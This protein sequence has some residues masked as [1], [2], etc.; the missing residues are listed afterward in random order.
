MKSSFQ[1]RSLDV[2]QADSL[3]T[4]RRIV[5]AV[6]SGNGSVAAISKYTGVSERHVRY[7][8]QAGR[9]LG[10]LSVDL[11]S[12]PRGRELL[13]TVAGGP[14]ELEVF[15]AC[16][17]GSSI[18]TRLAPNLLAEDKFDLSTV[19]KCIQLQAGLSPATADRRAS[20]LRSWHN[21][22]VKAATSVVSA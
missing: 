20:V 18:L 1:I 9:V 22:L 14:E 19:S 5:E 7:R 13:S 2:P 10:L 16:I 15:R 11:T 4:I 17:R 3:P 12:T 6:E 8:L 21:Q